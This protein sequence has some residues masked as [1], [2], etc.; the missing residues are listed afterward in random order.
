[1]KKLACVLFAVLAL[2]AGVARAQTDVAGANPAVIRLAQASSMADGEIRKVDKAAG[3]LT[4][5]HGPIP[6]I[7][8]PPMTMVFQVKDP[9]M[10]DQVK[11]GDK[12]KFTAEKTGGAFTVMTLEPAK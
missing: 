7:D 1:M 2:S 5:R 11:A 3:K 9:A 12:V 4:L 10:L 8:M 6:S